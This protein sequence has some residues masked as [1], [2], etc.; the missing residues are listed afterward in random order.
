[1]NT[2]VTISGHRGWRSKYLRG[3]Y[4]ALKQDVDASG[5]GKLKK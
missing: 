2:N 5:A 3:F 1:M 4:E